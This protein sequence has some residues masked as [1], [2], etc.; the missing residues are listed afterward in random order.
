[1]LAAFL[2]TTDLQAQTFG[3]LGGVNLADLLRGTGES[4]G[5]RPGLNAGGVLYL[6]NSWAGFQ[7][8]SYYAQKGADGKFLVQQDNSGGT[9]LTPTPTQAAIRFNYVENVGLARLSLPIRKV[10]PYIAG[11]YSYSV[12]YSCAVELRDDNQFI[13]DQKSCDDGTDPNTQL[14]IKGFDT[15]LILGGGIDVLIRGDPFGDDEQV[16]VPKQIVTIDV[17]YISGKQDVATDDSPLNN[18]K[19][20]VLAFTFRFPFEF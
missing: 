2:V 4:I 17:R 3:P 14:K 11:G 10:R 5:S 6:G 16:D 19:N 13:V 20:G 1:V 9:P 7:M 12:T 18:F 8:E 15:A